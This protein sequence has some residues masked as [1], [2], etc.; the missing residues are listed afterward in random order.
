MIIKFYTVKIF[1]YFNSS[2]CAD[3]QQNQGE[4]GIDCGGPCDACP[5]IKLTQFYMC[6][7]GNG[8]ITEQRNL[9]FIILPLCIDF[10]RRKAHVHWRIKT[11]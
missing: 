6:L 1:L 10:Y 3:G 7:L 11:L 5:G 9:C 4:L 2:T 8:K